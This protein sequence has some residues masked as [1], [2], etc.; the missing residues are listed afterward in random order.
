[1]VDATSFSLFE[2]DAKLCRVGL[3]LPGVHELATLSPVLAKGP[4]GDWLVGA[5]ALAR[6]LIAP[7]L[8]I[9]DLL[10]P[11]NPQAW[12]ARA[13][14]WPFARPTL[15][16][17][18]GVCWEIEHKLYPRAYL[19]SQ[20][21]VF[22]REL[23]EEKAQCEL[24]SMGLIAGRGVSPG[25]RVDLEQAATL[26]GIRR[27]WWVDRMHAL[28]LSM[29]AQRDQA[30]TEGS[31]TSPPPAQE[32]QDALSQIDEVLIG[33]TPQGPTTAQ[34]SLTEFGPSP[35]TTP[36]A[37]LEP[38]S[39]DEPEPPEE[40][41]DVESEQSSSEDELESPEEARDVESA[42]SPI[43]SPD[44]SQEVDVDE[45]DLQ[46]ASAPVGQWLWVADHLGLELAQ[47]SLD[48]E[49]ELHAR[50][51]IL[52]VSRLDWQAKVVAQLHQDLRDEQEIDLGER[53]LAQVRVWDASGKMMD[54]LATEAQ[55][56]LNL[57]HLCVRRDQSFHYQTSWSRR[58]MDALI[59]DAVHQLKACCQGPQ[60]QQA[61]QSLNGQEEPEQ[62]VADRWAWGRY[63]SASEIPAFVRVAQQCAWLSRKDARLPGNS[64]LLGAGLWI[65]ERQ[66]T[67]PRRLVADLMLGN[68]EWEHEEGFRKRCNVHGLRLPLSQD[69]DLQG[70][71]IDAEDGGVWS[72]Y[73]CL[74][75]ADPEQ[76]LRYCVS[77]VTI[78]DY[79]KDGRVRMEVQRNG[80]IVVSRSPAAKNAGAKEIEVCK[81]GLSP[82]QVLDLEIAQSQRDV[83]RFMG[84]R[85]R[86]MRKALAKHCA[87]LGRILAERADK[88]D[89][90]LRTRLGEWV[91]SAKER[92]TP[93]L[94]EQSNEAVLAALTPL[95]EALLAMVDT[96]SPQQKKSLGIE[97]V[98][99]PE[100]LEAAKELG[101]PSGTMPWWVFE[102][103]EGASS[104]AA[105]S[106]S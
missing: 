18:H 71:Q 65:E 46:E 82:E 24:R 35:A 79:E 55:T 105:V 50:D 85:G 12:Q 100:L 26:A 91:S 57:P 31:E 39:D 88:M 101:M 54:R 83:D 56:E 8:C 5:P 93:E 6:R 47:L 17:D 7:D 66:K 77:R 74:Q 44:A 3:S 94:E 61:E 86:A 9:L 34:L 22:A 52:G 95:H 73:L 98:A 10:E 68:L 106:T 40:A 25:L 76:E 70:A 63:G 42:Q 16:A 37:A 99:L 20:L 45:D 72:L 103:V 21:L 49:I 36:Q 27:L 14:S 62:T 58:R 23:A 87:D 104:P 48:P 4:D 89:D 32:E 53:R 28:A 1:M 75:G 97:L 80:K 84:M 51:L 102:E 29:K 59:A 2:L 81:R 64:A 38:A 69:F 11:A 41:H 92:L 43:E 30:L 33:A 15:H 67:G 78:A 96:F 90:L 13:G 60:G 19:L